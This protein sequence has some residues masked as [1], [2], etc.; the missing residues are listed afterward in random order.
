MKAKLLFLLKYYLFWIILSLFAKIIFLFYQ[1]Q[2]TMALTGGDLWNIF[3][4]GIPLDLSLGGYVIMLTAIILIGSSFWSEKVIR[5]VLSILTFLLLIF[6]S[7]VTTVDLELFK[8]WGFHIDSTPLMYLKTPKEAMAST[9]LWIVGFLLLLMIGYTAVAWLLFRRFVLSTLHYKGKNYLSIPIFLLI[10]GSMLIPIRGGFNVAPLNSSFVFFHPKNMYANQAAVNP[11]WNFIYELM[12]LEKIGKQYVFMPEKRAVQIVDSVMQT[13]TNYPRL[14][15]TNRP[16][17]VFLLLESFTANA[18]EA[19]GGVAGITP[20]LNALAHEGI[21]FSNIYAT[22]SRS[23]RG[24]VAAI[25]AFPSH[26]AIAMIKYPNKMMEHPRFPKDLEKMGYATRYYYAGDINFGSFRSYVTM[27]FQDMVTEDDFSGEAIKNRF[28]WGV[29]DQY[30]FERLYED[31][32]KAP[33]PFM[34]MAFNMSSHEPF[35]VP[36]E[37][38]IP[39]N[40]IEHQ[41]MNAIHYSDH[42]I[43]EFIRKCKESGIWDHTLF[44]LMA[45]H[46]TRHIMHIDPS[47]PAA[48]HIPLILTGGVLNVRDTVITTIGSQTDMVA[49][50]LAQLDMD[51]ST[52]K[53]SRNLLANPIIPFAF[54][55]YP[56]AA[57]VISEHGVS[58]LDLQGLHFIQEDSLHKN[59]EL[60]KAYLQSINTDVHQ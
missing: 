7:I 39:G 16:N 35:N 26:P 1:W 23:D 5:L 32:E 37:I 54:Y 53:Y 15:K 28:K 57:G 55:S 36:G 38:K 21:V 40:D 17:I 44:V 42:C 52:Y 13:G 45:D 33:Q 14:L 47:S 9:P 24:M 8:N 11:V 59:N 19:I 41:F 10:G 12:H 25:S 29:H 34:Y 18:I 43:G 4:K 3:V 49:T 58:I 48:Y 31:I 6:F 2:D 56:N 20:T 46:G 30:M 22:S 27:S 60:L 51:H 50:L